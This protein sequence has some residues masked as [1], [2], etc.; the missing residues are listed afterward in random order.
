MSARRTMLLLHRWGGLG[1]A[2]FLLVAALTGCALVFRPELDAALNPELF[3]APPGPV[4]PAPELA[5]RLAL[6]HPDWVLRSVPV[7]SRTGRALA[8]DVRPV[9][10]GAVR[11]AD[12]VFVDPRNGGVL[13]ARGRAW[14]LDRAHLFGTMLALHYTLLAGGPGRWLMGVAAV[15]WL[16]LNLLGLVITWPRRA[17]KLRNWAPSW[18]VSRWGMRVRPLIELHRV[19]GLWLV[20]LLS[21]LAYTSVAFNFYYELFVPAV[22]ELS[23]PR[24]GGPFDGPAPKAGAAAPQGR[25][26]GF[27]AAL[28][29]A[30]RA[31]AA[32]T[33]GLAP[34]TMGEDRARG[35]YEVGFSPG[36]TSVYRNA[37][38]VTYYLGRTDGRLIWIDQPSLDGLGKELERTLYPL[39]SGQV[40]GLPTRIL[41]LVLGLVMAGLTLTGFIPWWK[42][43]RSRRRNARTARERVAA[44]GRGGSRA[45]AGVNA[46]A[47]GRTAL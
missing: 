2:L 12:E 24:R 14:G 21:V 46:T 19:A 7:R 34:A 23:P 43:W 42:R 28:A 1:V 31:A 33:P 27:A 11:K 36:G 6:A 22:E 18:T 3:S 9:D 40:F 8:V 26:I 25:A 20:I 41:V 29:A 32:H 44:E 35:F 10:V 5:E 17:P 47:G 15:L 45:D 16:V 39:H 4:L 37:G 13:G 38:P 30:E